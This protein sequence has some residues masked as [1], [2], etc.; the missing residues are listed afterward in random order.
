MKTTIF[1][2]PS[3]AGPD[4]LFSTGAVVDGAQTWTADLPDVAGSPDPSWNVTQWN[5][6]SDQVFDPDAPTGGDADALLGPALA[7]WNTGAAGDGSSFAVFGSAGDATFR[8]GASGG[9]TRDTFLQTTGYAAATVTFDHQI[10]FTADERVAAAVAGSGTA[11]AFN[12][13]TVF[14]NEAGS[15]SYDPSLPPSRSS[16]R[17]R[18]S[19]SGASRAPMRRSRLATCTSRSTTCPRST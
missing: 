12:A 15:P 13:F 8:V 2:D 6:P 7:A 3:V 5:T 9:S 18:W 17:C 16:C 10:T 14:F 1:A 4:I 11:I 19:T